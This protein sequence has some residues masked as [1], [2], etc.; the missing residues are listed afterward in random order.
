MVSLTQEEWDDLGDPEKGGS[1]AKQKAHLAAEEKIVF[2]AD[3]QKKKG[4]PIEQGIGSPG[5]EN[6]NHFAAI[7]K[8][9]GEEA[10][11]KALAEA[12]KRRG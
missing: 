12:A 5:R 6:P 10:Y 9:E 4:V 11:Q 7:R 8:N 1:I 2:G 3:F